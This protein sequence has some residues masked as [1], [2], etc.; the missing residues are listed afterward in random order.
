MKDFY[1]NM[2]SR[3]LNLQR[4]VSNCI[5]TALYIAG[6]C[7]S[8]NYLS[9]KDSMKII[10]KMQRAKDPKLGYL[11]L[12]ESKGTIFHA[13]VVYMDNPFYI[14][15]RNKNKGLPMHSSLEDYKSY[16]LKETG[17]APTYRIPNSLLNKI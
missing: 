11:V 12:W 14:I 1:K 8:D 4:D 5:G 2:E 6:E 17:I 7:D 15:H 9:R 13:G 10:N 3:A 16:L